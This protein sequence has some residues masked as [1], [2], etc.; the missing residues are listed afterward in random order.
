MLTSQVG[1]HNPG[2]ERRVGL[3]VLKAIQS[4]LS[5]REAFTLQCFDCHYLIALGEVNR[6]GPG[7]IVELG[8]TEVIRIAGEVDPVIV[9]NSVAIQSSVV[10][11]KTEITGIFAV[12]FIGRE[13]ILAELTGLLR[14]QRLI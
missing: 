5:Q 6:V 12:L 14:N 2:P 9:K 8:H 3:A 11:A 1:D 4:V 13:R 10:Y 7:G